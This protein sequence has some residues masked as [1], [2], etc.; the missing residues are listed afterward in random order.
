MA[1]Y[2]MYQAHPV[3][4]EIFVF[5]CVGDILVGVCGPIDYKEATASNLGDFHCTEEDVEW[6]K[7]EAS[8]YH[9]WRSMYEPYPG[10]EVR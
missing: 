6:A 4:G 1:S 2:Q 8:L 3:S 7:R 10:D 9:G 5:E